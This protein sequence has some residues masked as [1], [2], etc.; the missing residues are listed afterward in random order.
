MSTFESRR[1]QRSIA[2]GILLTLLACAAD[3]FGHLEPLEGWFYDVRAANCQFFSSKP[4]DRIVHIEIDD[5]SLSPTA[6]GRWPWPRRKLARILDEIG[7]ANP[8]AIALDVQ[9]TEPETVEEDETPAGKIDDDKIL[10]ESLK[11]QKNVILATLFHLLPSDPETPQ[12]VAARAEMTQ[13]LELTPDELLEKIRHRGRDFSN[14]FDVEDLFAHARSQAMHARV[15]EELEQSALTDDQLVSKLLPRADPHVNSPLRRVLMQEASNFRN[16]KLFRRFGMEVPQLK[17][18]VVYGEFDQMPVPVLSSNASYCGFVNFNIFPGATLREIPLLV[19]SEGRVYPQM[20]FALGCSVLGVDVRHARIEQNQIVLKKPDGSQLRVPTHGVYSS[21]LGRSFSGI[22]DIPYFGGKHWETMY[23]WPEN[24]KK[25][26]QL[27][28]NVVWDICATV[29]KIRANNRSY[30]QAVHDIFSSTG[31]FKWED[32]FAR[33]YAEKPPELDDTDAREK[34]SVQA[35]ARLKDSQL[36][37]GLQ[38]IAPQQ[39]TAEENEE[40]DQLLAAQKALHVA[41]NNQGLYQQLTLLRTRLSSQL[42]HKG[43][44]VGFAAE[45]TFDVVNTSLVVH[46]PGVIIHGIIAQAVLSGRWWRQSPNWVGVCLILLLGFTETLSVARLQPLRAG[47][48][49]LLLL[50]VYLLIN[51]YVLFDASSWIIPVAGPVVAISAVWSGCTLQRVIHEGIERN[52]VATE[53]AI[54]NRE[55]DLAHQVQAALIPKLPP[56]IPGLEAQGWTLPASTTGGDCYDLWALGDGRL[57]ILVADASGHGLAPAMIVSQVRTLVRAMSE[58]ELHPHDLLRRIN[59]RVAEDLEVGRFIT[60]FLGFLSP[61]G[62]LEYASAGHGPQFFYTTECCDLIELPSTGAPLGCDTQWLCD[63]PLPP[64]QIPDNGTLAVF[65]DGIFEAID[66]GGDLF[67]I[68]RLKEILHTQ[69][70]QP[71]NVI[72]QQVIDAMLKWQKKQQPADDQTVVI[73]RRKIVV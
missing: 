13:N 37:Q 39:R 49:T 50:S 67:G 35:L 51:G 44:L 14:L 42:A 69:R 7:R 34:H 11:H 54:I 60:V 24:R 26:N 20:G 3:Q 57:A 38:S 56:G 5:A 59:L 27:S 31:P 25:A 73:A 47:C 6:V 30:D 21:A 52:R 64:I 58:M 62:L 68:D 33:P 71:V 15:C 32:S 17:T 45:G 65:S 8:A 2:V 72:I 40:L 1:F 55:M 43:V 29:D 12:Q 48:V 16:R 4:D 66:P 19:E 36:I 22:A 46:C 70:A 41:E 61:D 63:D 23:D 18:P 28:A 9:L 53:V 10:A